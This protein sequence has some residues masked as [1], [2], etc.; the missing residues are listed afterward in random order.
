MSGNYEKIKE[1]YR[2]SYSKNG[3][4][5]ASLLTPKGRHSL[6]FRSIVPHLVPGKGT[7]VLDFGCGL[8]YLYEYASKIC[9]DIVYTGADIMPEF[10]DAC[11]N[12]FGELADFIKIDPNTTIEQKYD[13]IFGSGVFNI[14]MGKSEEESKAYVFD[15]LKNL[16][17]SAQEVLICD[18]VSSFV[19]FKQG[20]TLHF[21][22]GEIAT[23]C[24][25]NLSRRFVLHHDFLPYE[26]TL[27]AYKNDK[28]QKPGNYYV[29]D[30]SLMEKE[31]ASL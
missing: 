2:E 6:R 22:M 11:R 4:S 25:Q 28:I 19:D 16:F 9:P 21:D 29:A 24:S 18:F 13:I 1:M 8:G 7:T 12:K 23:F 20:D 3:D 15:T 10:V 27:V 14:K 31:G 30:S 17:D 26:F 5:P